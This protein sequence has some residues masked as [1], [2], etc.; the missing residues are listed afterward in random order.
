MQITGLT[1]QVAALQAKDVTSAIDLA[2]W[3]DSAGRK[4]NEGCLPGAIG[5]PFTSKLQK[6]HC[7]S[8]H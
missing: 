8:Y 3:R 2:I 6:H 5:I 1:E 7:C 4:T